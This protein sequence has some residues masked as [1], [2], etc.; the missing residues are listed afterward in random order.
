MARTRIARLA[1]TLRSRG[2]ALTAAVPP[3]AAVLLAAA[4]LVLAGAGCGSSHSQSSATLPRTTQTTS[5]SPAGGSSSVVTG[6][7][8]GTLR[9][10]NHA[11]KVNQ[12]W[13]YSVRVSDGAG[14]PLSGTVAI[15]FMYGG[16][17]VGRDTPP[18]HPMRDGRWHDAITFPAPAV[19]MPLTFR[20]AVRTQAGS[21]NLDWP[22]K[23]AP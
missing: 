4:G 13:R 12:A 5:A 8:R 20:A 14:H 7:V 21:I 17:V 1:H 23:V 2:T 15:E 10:Q 18:T 22:V 19:E 6:P 3:A 16:Q 9:G 11:P